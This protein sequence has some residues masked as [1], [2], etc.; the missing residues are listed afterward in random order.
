MIKEY[1]EVNL[2]AERNGQFLYI[3]TL[4]LCDS[5]QEA[6]KKLEEVKDESYEKEGLF[7]TISK[8][9]GIIVEKEYFRDSGITI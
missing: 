3:R 1:F 2:H 5:A 4:F 8:T 6:I 9:R 7:L